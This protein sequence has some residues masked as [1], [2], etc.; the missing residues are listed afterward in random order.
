MTKPTTPSD[1]SGYLLVKPDE[2]QLAFGS[3]H[4]FKAASHDTSGRF[5]FL[6][7]AMAPRAGPPLHCQ[8][9]LE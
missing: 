4:Q 3:P 7:M 9:G 6:T 2:A 5:D 8:L 1:T